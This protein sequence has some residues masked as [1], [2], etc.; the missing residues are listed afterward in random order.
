[1]HR[2]QAGLPWIPKALISLAAGVIGG[3]AVGT[4]AAFVGSL[5]P[6]SSRAAIGVLSVVLLFATSA[7][8][9][10]IEIGKETRQSLLNLGPVR[11]A[12]VNGA[13]LGVALTSRLAFRLW[14]IAPLIAF[15]LGNWTFGLLLGAVYGAARLATIGVLAW[16][17]RNAPPSLVCDFALG[18][19]SR[20]NR[21]CQ[22]ILV[23]AGL[24]ILI[25]VGP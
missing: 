24:F 23:L 1:V 10:M 19:R 9:R 16:R 21:A 17:M 15:M 13:L 20:A 18:Q 7:S 5:F 8:P 4:L 25:T 3:A 12:A 6:T 11:W 2:N 14:Y 22:A